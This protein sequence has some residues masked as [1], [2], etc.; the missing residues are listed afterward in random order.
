MEGKQNVLALLVRN[1]PLR[2]A[3]SLSRT[4]MDLVADGKLVAGTRMPT[5]RDVANAMAM[6]ATS[7]AM[8][9]RELVD[10]RVLETKRRGGT[11]VLGPPRAPRAA[12]FDALTSKAA[13]VPLNL[14]Y[15]LS[16]PK[17]IP[18]LGPA[19][20][21]A[22]A[23]PGINDYTPVPISPALR[24]VATDMWP[25]PPKFLLATH[26][27]VCAIE[28]ALRTTVRPGDRVLVEVP[29]LPRVFDILEAIGATIVPLPRVNGGPDLNVLAQ[30]LR[31]RPVALVYQPFGHNPTGLSVT[32]DWVHQAASLLR[33]EHVA[34]FELVL[35]P[36]LRRNQSRIRSIGQHLPHS[37][38]HIQS[39]NFFFGHNVRVAVA[40]GSDYYIDR[41]WQSFTFSSRW[42]S[43]VLQDAVAF[44]L[45][46]PSAGA[47]LRRFIDTC[48]SRH[49]LFS[50][51]LRAVGFELQ[52][53]EGPMI[54]LP[55]PDE[56]HVADALLKDGIMTY[57]GSNFS[58]VL[59]AQDFLSLNGTLLAEGHARIADLLARACGR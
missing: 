16:D 13:T 10:W 47:H 36:L 37:V 46:D 11:I 39:F 52:E 3:R 41:M 20:A 56:K 5:V 32:A 15:T 17:L 48:Y 54:W 6:S 55:V 28:M 57:G 40:G 30:S 35:S 18:P 38:V 14:G 31:S 59:L 45:T 22:A 33:D 7:V 51:A 9:W 24:A 23:D 53:T 49:A 1:V 43:R 58:P 2:T 34:V 27:G 8:A 21:A 4:I 12:R 25:F 19:L 44:Q 26:G 42:V 29:S 50:E